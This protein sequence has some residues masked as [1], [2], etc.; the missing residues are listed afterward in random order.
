MYE[1]ALRTVDMMHDA[2]ADLARTVVSALNDGKVS[3]WEGIALS[4]RAV[5]LGMVVQSLCQDLTKEQRNAILYVL[6]H[7]ELMLP[8][9]Q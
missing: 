5:Q 2:L 4:T 8:K 6:E 1:E 9:G 7:G 3:V